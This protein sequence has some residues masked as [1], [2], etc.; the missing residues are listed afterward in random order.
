MECLLANHGIETQA[1]EVKAY[2]LQQHRKLLRVVVFSVLQVDS[3]GGFPLA[4]QLLRQGDVP[5]DPL[6]RHKHDQGV[7]CDVVLYSVATALCLQESST[8]EL[9]LCAE[10]Y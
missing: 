7:P 3:H 10:E 9:D 1:D 2:A 8:L 4:P 6:H 5:R